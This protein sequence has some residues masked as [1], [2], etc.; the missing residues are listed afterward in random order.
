MSLISRCTGPLDLR[1]FSRR[2]MLHQLG[3]GMGGMALGHL[4]GGSS[5]QAG[6]GLPSLP[7][8]APKAK[9]VIF[10]FMSGGV[11]QLDA[12]D[13]KPDLKKNTG[14]QLPDS[15][16][17]GKDQFLPGMAGHQNHF[18]LAGSPYEFKQHGQ[19]GAWVSDQWPHTAK[20]VD[21]LSFIYSM[22]SDAVNH[23]PAMIFMNSGSQLPGRPSMGAWLSYGLGSASENLPAFITL[24]S[25][26]P[27]D[28]PLSSRLWDSGFLPSQ[29]QGV[30]FRAAHDPVLY[31]SEPP[32]SRR[33]DTR[34]T[35]D[36]LRELQ[37][38]SAAQ[39]QIESEL[40]SRIEQYEMAFRMQTSV[41]EVTDVSKEPDSVF[42]LYGPKSREAG[43]LEANCILARR[44]AQQ[45]VRFI[46]LYHPGWDHH[47]KLP[48][49]YPPQALSADRA[50]ASLV[51][52][53]KNHGMLEDTLLVWGTEFG[54][55]CFSQGNISKTGSFG[56]DHHRNC[57]TFWMTG[58]GVKRGFQYGATDEL[59]YRV[60]QNPVTVN[61]FHATLLHLLGVDHERFTY[62]FQGRDFRLT[63]VA[64]RVVKEILA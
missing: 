28:Q 56:R 1:R 5:A 61:D 60:A 37:Q 16:R 22:T 6:T 4:L 3:M 33:E 59:G 48:M 44:L 24:I 35:I 38:V 19:S 32:G 20:V 29:Y 10:L 12:F 45:G 47:G 14:N 62:R 8:F 41:P 51:Q 23:D 31:L 49:N 27:V 17:G 64:G 21:D 7:H 39:D 52:D 30:Q 57:F 63:D 54:R 46:Q 34:R 18:Y 53:L 42:E 26:Y 11:S 43:S 25:K 13:Y 9:R 36:A 2:Q 50:C 55:T 15:L 40:S 58:A